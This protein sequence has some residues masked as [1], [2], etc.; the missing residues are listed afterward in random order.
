MQK[1]SVKFQETE[2]SI[3]KGLHTIT[4]GFINRNAIIVQH[5]KKLISVIHHINRGKGRKLLMIF[6]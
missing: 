1:S 5:T 2:F 6:N 4:N 3:L